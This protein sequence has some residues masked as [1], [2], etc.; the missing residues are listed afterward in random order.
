MP[1]QYIDVWGYQQRAD[2]KV[3]SAKG[4]TKRCRCKGCTKPRP[5]AKLRCPEC[6]RAADAQ[7]VT[8]GGEEGSQGTCLAR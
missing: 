3:A 1:G 5:D 6:A 4:Y 8:G 7:R 2:L